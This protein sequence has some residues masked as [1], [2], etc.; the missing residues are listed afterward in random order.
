MHRGHPKSDFRSPCMSYHRSNY[1]GYVSKNIIIDK[2]CNT[3]LIQYA[4]R[5]SQKYCCHKCYKNHPIQKEK[6]RLNSRKNYEKNGEELRK[7]HREWHRRLVRKKKC[8]PMDF[9][10]MKKFSGEGYVAKSGYKYFGIK[11][12]PLANKY[13]RV[14]EHKLIIFNHIGRILRKHESIHHKNG[15]RSDNR[16]ENLELWSKSQPSGQRVED[17]IEWCKEFLNEYGIKVID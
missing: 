2:I 10:R 11:N 14:A 12:H 15:I 6:N 7:Y 9:P 13:G 17:K 1:G 16:I 4:G 3:C 8:L 5:K